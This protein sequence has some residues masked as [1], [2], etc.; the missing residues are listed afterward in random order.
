MKPLVIGLGNRWRGDDGIGAQVIEQ[1]RARHLDGVDL[2]DCPGDNMDLIN[3]W[4]D[5][6]CAYVIDACVD[7][8]LADGEVIT[9]EQASANHATLSRLRHPTSSHVLDL[10]QALA[11]SEALDKAPRKLTVFAIAGSRFDTGTEPQLVVQEAGLRLAGKL[12]TLLSPP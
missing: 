5:R 3:S 11:L 10:Q 9:I 6:D 7:A 12:A 1:L 8:T 4:Q 2:R